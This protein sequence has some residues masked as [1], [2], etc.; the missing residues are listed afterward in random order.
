[1]HARNSRDSNC[2]NYMKTP[3]EV[4]QAAF[5]AM[6]IEDWGGLADLCDP[7][8]LRLFKAELLDQFAETSPRYGKSAESLFEIDFDDVDDEFDFGLI[9]PEECLSR[10]L[11]NVTTLDQLREMDPARVFAR[12][13][14]AKLC[15]QRRI[16]EPPEESWREPVESP[17]SGTALVY[18]FAVLG[19]LND[20]PDL[21]HVL[22]RN[23]RD[24][25]GK[26]ITAGARARSD[27]DQEDELGRILCVRSIPMTALCRRQADDSW[28]LVVS[29]S[30]YL[31]ASMELSDAN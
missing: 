21:A 14:Q 8:S 30:L 1:M 16:L 11:F 24:I 6:N 17:L 9:D 4:V 26:A 18:S 10:E 31:V 28:R 19:W 29:S 15:R 13:I 22:Y 20:G 5:H 3:A 25:P 7:V 27:A 12:W 2:G 23:D